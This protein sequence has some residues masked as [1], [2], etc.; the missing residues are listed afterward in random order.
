MQLESNPVTIKQ[1]GMRGCYILN[2]HTLS[3]QLTRSG[4]QINAC[5]STNKHWGE[6]C[7]FIILCESH[8]I[9][10]FLNMFVFWLMSLKTN[11]MFHTINKEFPIENISSKG[12]ARQK[13]IEPE[14][15]INVNITTVLLC[16][17]CED[18]P[19]IFNETRKR[20]L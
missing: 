7:L 13:H 4:P 11:L 2:S 17:Y 10:L 5:D 1:K 6:F 3:V 8:F 20:K 19:M 18:L 15:T 9:L 16:A 12:T 14:L